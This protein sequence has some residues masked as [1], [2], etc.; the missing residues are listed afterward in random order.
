MLAAMA[1]LA[2]M[3]PG[4]SRAR[5]AG[6]GV[7]CAIASF[8][9]QPRGIGV[10]LAL[11]LFLCWKNRRCDN[12][13]LP[14]WKVQTLLFS[15]FIVATAGLNLYFVYEAGWKRFWWCTVVFGLKYY[16]AESK[17]NSIHSYL[18]Y[19]PRLSF[20]PHVPEPGWILIHVMVP[21]V[22]LFFFAYWWRAR[23][24][25]P[26]EPWDRI[27]L[28]SLVGLFLFL[29]VAPAPITWRMQVIALPAILVFVWLLESPRKLAVAGRCVLWVWMVAVMTCVV[30]NHQTRW[31][32]V[33][34]TPTGRAAF[35][36]SGEFERY[37]WLAEHTHPLEPYFDCSGKS[38]FLLDLRSPARVSF[39]SG[40]DYLR[41][42]QVQDLVENLAR[43]RVRVV[44]W[45]SDLDAATR[46]DD[47]LG[48]LRVYLR[49]H[50]HA[51]GTSEGLSGILVRDPQPLSP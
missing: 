26:E 22:F 24:R 17:L 28:I 32:A 21:F 10:V 1:A 39:L 25:K 33:L 50:Y 51:V 31:R 45:C 30:W 48:P 20:L 27:M 9:T 8:F 38:Y 6:A 14:L 23:R 36:E 5:I 41:P 49:S 47:H 37:K 2:L 16:P 43:K 29:G 19:P 34:D 40:T 18:A 35:F 44:L 42:E 7:L 46:P 3:I 11:A 12:E 4:I 15:S 13:G